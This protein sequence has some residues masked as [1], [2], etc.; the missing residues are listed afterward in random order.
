[1]CMFKCN[2]LQSGVMYLDAVTIALAV[3]S[4][5]YCFLLHC[6]H[7]LRHNLVDGRMI[8][9][10]WIKFIAGQQHAAN[11][12]CYLRNFVRKG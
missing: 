9:A 3:F 11:R 2:V 4:K 12:K 6:T 5:S 7:R 8:F 10:R 1:M